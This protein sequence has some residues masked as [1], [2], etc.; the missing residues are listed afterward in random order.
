MDY[1][2]KKVGPSRIVCG[3]DYPVGD[4]D[5]VGYVNRAKGVSSADKAAILGG[6][7]AKLLGLSI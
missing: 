7:A 3:S 1:L 2:V 5:P 6:N 4:E